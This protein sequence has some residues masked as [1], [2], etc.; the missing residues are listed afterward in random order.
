[1]PTCR[2]W[3][4]LRN[5]F[6]TVLVVGLGSMG[7]AAARTLAARGLRV[8]LLAVASFFQVGTSH[9]HG[10]NGFLCDHLGVPGCKPLGSEIA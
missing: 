6:D 4:E 10:L 8:L 9:R 7:A 2:R 3:L 1:M 5:G